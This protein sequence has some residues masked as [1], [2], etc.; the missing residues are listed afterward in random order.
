MRGLPNLGNTCYANTALQCLWTSGSF[1]EYMKKN[2][3]VFDVPSVFEADEISQRIRLYKQMIRH[4]SLSIP[5]FDFSEQMDIHEFMTFYLDFFFECF[6][7]IVSVQKPQIMT[8]NTKISYNLDA[9]WFNSYSEVCDLIYAQYL[10]HTECTSC[11]HSV[12][13]YETSSVLALAIPSSRTTLETCIDEYFSMT[14]VSRICDKCQHDRSIRK[15]YLCKLPK[16]FICCLKRFQF[17]ENQISKQT[18]PVTVPNHLNLSKFVKFNTKLPHYKLTSVALHYGSLD[19]GHYTALIDEGE[20]FLHV[21]D[22]N[23][24]RMSSSSLPDHMASNSYMIFYERIDED[25]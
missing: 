14:D 11:H 10:I 16:L 7:R 4:M 19:D 3:V 25:I 20:E 13:N 2:D 8:T 17:S 21:D 12:Y 5:V 1:R 23:E 9:Q 6:K 22:F 15:T 18:T 24:H